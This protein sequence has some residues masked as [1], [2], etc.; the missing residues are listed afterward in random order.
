VTNNYILN[1]LTINPA[2]AGNSGALNIAAFYRRQWVGIAGSPETMKLITDFPLLG[3]K[4]GLGFILGSD[5]IGVTKSTK[6]NTA[7]AYRIK[8][9]KS[10]LSFGLGLGIL[11]TNTKW[12]DLV[13][14]D[15]GDENYLTDSR[16]FVVPDF[17]FGIYYSGNNFFTSVSIPNLVDYEFNYNTNKYNL[18]VSPGQYLYLISGG[19]S[20]SLGKKTVFT[21]S[22][23]ISFAPGTKATLDINSYFTFGNRLLL[24]ASYRSTGSIIG[25]FQIGIN[26][27]MK[28]A[29]SYDFTLSELGRYN[30]GSHE[31]MLRYEF[32]YKVNVV[33]PLEY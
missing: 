23:L 21:P 5:K 19:Y 15:P 29:Y 9:K 4:V 12:S 32:K 20:F 14:I 2:Y 18:D 1:Q 3:K 8:M 6:I 10:S 30:S 33:S 26:S 22:S 13:V 11:T 28:L 24:G 17:N 7:Y 16:I 31:L 27:Q 25:M